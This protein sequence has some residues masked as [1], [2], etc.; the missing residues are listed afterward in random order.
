[1]L[2]RPPQRGPGRDPVSD[3]IERRPHAV[4]DLPSRRWK[5]LKIERLLGL[6]DDGPPLRLLEIGTGAGGISAYFGQHP[7][8]RY[9]V[10]GVDVVDSRLV[11][12]GYQFHLVDGTQLPFGDDSFD[13]V[14]SNHVIE[15]VGDQ[16]SQLEHLA[17]IRRVLRPGGRGYLAV[18]NRWML[19]EPHYQLAFLS[20]LPRAWRTPYLRW[21]GKGD[22]Y[23]CEPLQLPEL[24][25][26]LATSGFTFR[27]RGVEALRQTLAIER[28]DSALARIVAHVPDRALEVFRRLIPTH[29]YVFEHARS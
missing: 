18:P 19:R 6:G 10:D 12:D 25:Q 13:I 3:A 16:A 23:D 9:S 14:L 21:S 24:E 1:M 29:I 2:R 26:F 28:P 7:S 11:T 15:H 17:E 27:N 4:L 5:A 22:F 20:W 8:G